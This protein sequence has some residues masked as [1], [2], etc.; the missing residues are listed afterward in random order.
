M[1]VIVSDAPRTVQVQ[2]LQDGD[3]FSWGTCVSWYV[4]Q[5]DSYFGLGS[6]TTNSIKR[7]VGTPIV[8]AEAI[9]VFKS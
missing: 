5:G 9:T 4:K 2:E 8:R 1:K 7:L 3:V 6:V